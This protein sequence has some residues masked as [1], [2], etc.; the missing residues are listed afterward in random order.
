MIGWSHNDLIMLKIMMHFVQMT[1]HYYVMQVLKT[2]KKKKAGE[3]ILFS[4]DM[5]KVKSYR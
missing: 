5:M 2:L 3:I 1:A 4:I